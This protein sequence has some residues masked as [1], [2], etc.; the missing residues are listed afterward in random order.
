MGSVL[1]FWSSLES[2]IA[3]MSIVQSPPRRAAFRRELILSAFK[4]PNIPPG[5][6]ESWPVTRAPF[7]AVEIP[8][9]F[10]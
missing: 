5:F 7:S 8:P 2:I 1:F 3:A 4:F 10:F 9:F 6:L